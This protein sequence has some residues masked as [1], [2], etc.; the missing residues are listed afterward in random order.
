MKLNF[1]V[2]AVSLR[3][4]TGYQSLYL[5]QSDSPNF[6]DVIFSKNSI[7]VDFHSLVYLGYFFIHIYKRH[8]RKQLC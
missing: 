2:L 3:L 4:P 5:R 7:A 1:M 8:R 6:P